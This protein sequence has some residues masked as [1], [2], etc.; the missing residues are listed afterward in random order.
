MKDFR[1]NLKI[2]CHPICYRP[3]E[4]IFVCIYT[5][6][7]IHV[8]IRVHVY[9]YIVKLKTLFSL[10]FIYI[11]THKYIL[12]FPP[13]HKKVQSI[14]KE[15]QPCGYTHTHIHTHTQLTHT[16]IHAYTHSHIHTYT[17][18]HTHINI[19][20]YTHKHTHTSCMHTPHTYTNAIHEKLIKRTSTWEYRTKVPTDRQQFAVANFA[21]RIVVLGGWLH[22]PSAVVCMCVYVCVCA[23]ICTCIYICNI[24]GEDR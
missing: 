3:Y 21:G 23:C 9:V 18:T 10:V 1:N 19:H 15:W 14:I 22:G 12:L 6:L 16:T 17:H 8:H 20:T 4:C 2:L 24:C 7:H 5:Y 11:Y 13:W